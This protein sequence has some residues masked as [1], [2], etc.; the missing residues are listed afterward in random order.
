MKKQQSSQR[1]A[2]AIRQKA[3]LKLPAVARRIQRNSHRAYRRMRLYFEL[4]VFVES[5]GPG[6]YQELGKDF[7]YGDLVL[8]QELDRAIDELQD[9]IDKQQELLGGSGGGGVGGSD[10]GK[11]DPSEKPCATFLQEYQAALKIKDY[12]AAAKYLK[13]YSDCLAQPRSSSPVSQGR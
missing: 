8:A 4:L 12:V 6:P 11:A 5:A 10:G 1:R 13:E 3:L 9:L 2:A 7:T